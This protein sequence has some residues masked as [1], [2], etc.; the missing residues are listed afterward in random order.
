MKRVLLLTLPFL[1]C[2]SVGIDA[3]RGA[4]TATTCPATLNDIRD[5]P[6]QGC[7]KKFDPNLN[8]RKNATSNSG[9]P[10]PR[11]IAFIKNLADPEEFMTGDSREELEALGEGQMVRVAAFLIAIKPE[12]A[13]S[14]NCGLTGVPNT[15]NHLVLV[16]STTVEKFTMTGSADTQKKKFH[17]RELESVTAEFTPRVRLTHPNFTRAKVNPLIGKTKEKALF[18]R[19]TGPLTFDSEHF[20]HNP[21]VR[22]TDWEIHPILKFEICMNGDEPSK[23]CKANSDT[24][25]K[26]LDSL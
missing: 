7:G 20:F 18:V 8:E 9:T 22:A 24:G 14:C 25:W 1:L 15:D 16:T 26:N 3:Q 6:D 10:T 11:T 17:S 23:T 4:S 21:L 2:L 5:C 13:E 19:V 12:G